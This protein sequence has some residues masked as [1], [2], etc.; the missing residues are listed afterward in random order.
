MIWNREE[1]IAHMTF[2]DTGREMFTELFG[3]L[4]AL[5]REWRA[6]GVAEDEIDLSRFGW[7]SV[8]YV[9]LNCNTGAVTGIGPRV[10]SDTP[11][12]QI[13]IDGMGRKSRLCKQSATIPLPLEYPVATPDDWARLRR[14]YEFSE[15][16][17]DVEGLKRARELQKQGYL[18]LAG[19]PGGFDEPRQ[20]LGE[21]G[22]CVAFYDEPEMIEDMLSVMADTTLKVFE[23]ALDYVVIDNLSVHE[24]LAGKSG[25][26]AGPAQIRRFIRP[27][28]R[29]VWD[30][31]KRHGGSLFSQDSD[32][33][34]I[35]RD[36][37][38]PRLRRQHHVSL[39]AG[40]RHGYGRDPEKVRQAPRRERRHRQI[41]AARLEGGHRAGA[42]LQDER[43]HP[44]RRRGLRAGSPHSQRRSH[45]KLPLLRE[46]GPGTAGSAARR[47]E[48]L[49]AHGVLNQSGNDGRTKPMNTRERFLRTMD[50]RPVDRLPMLEWATWWDKTVARWKGEGLVIS[51]VEGLYEG[52]AL[53]V[54]MGL[55]LHL[56]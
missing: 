35:P 30:E 20:L 27:Y 21:E 24:D 38:F 41:R 31:V 2:Q 32:G 37:R 50:F 9:W 42:D 53:Q 45:R 1:Y 8:K 14:W 6:A 28:Y 49:R 4:G 7:D 12:E 55:D 15:D 29:K 51:P 56:Q 54:Q 26:L 40:L 52:E 46:A 36:R 23:R 16:R 48:S 33:N 17:I 25:P 39:R 47:A 10:I 18:V 22:L 3:P 11:E 5:E 44:R 34:M 13:L 43:P 19:M